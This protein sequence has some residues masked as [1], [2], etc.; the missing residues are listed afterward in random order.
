MVLK[1]NSDQLRWVTPKLGTIGIATFGV[2][3]TDFIEI[4][5]IETGQQIVFTYVQDYFYLNKDTGVSI[6]IKNIL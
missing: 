5:S 3:Q 6:V 2:T 4:N 1:L